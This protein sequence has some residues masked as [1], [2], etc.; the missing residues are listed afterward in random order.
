MC[1]R[2]SAGAL[3][4]RA[5]GGDDGAGG[6][7]AAVGEVLLRGFRASQ[8]GRRL[9][10]LKTLAAEQ[11]TCVFFESPRRLADCLRDAV[12]ALGPSRKAVVCR[13]LTK[14]HEEIIRGTLAELA[15]WAADGVL[16]EI[17]V[18]LAGATP[19]ADLETLVA[20]VQELVDD[21]MR[22]KDACAQVVAAHPGAPSRRE[23]YEAVLRSRAIIFCARRASRRGNLRLCSPKPR[24]RVTALESQMRDLADRVRTSEQD[25]A[26][27]RVLA[28]AADRDVT[29]FMSEFRDFRRATTS[30]FHALREEMNERFAQVEERFSGDTL[31]GIS[32]TLRN[33]SRRVDDGF[34]EMRGKLDGAAAGQ[35]RIVEILER[36]IADQ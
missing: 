8:E 20:E 5:V 7:R 12:D 18:V 10:W 21:G 28:G 13:E 34:I 2:G 32:H 23:L 17:T 6:V 22:V 4:A 30:S 29:E 1:G 3:P 14:T 24:S 35:Q 25:A 9:A 26:A 16:G 36:L 19:K 11:R 27:A 31:T 15:E 33:A